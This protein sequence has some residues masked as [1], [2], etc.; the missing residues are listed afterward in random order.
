MV[1][2]GLHELVVEIHSLRAGKT[3]VAFEQRVLKAH[4]SQP[5]R[6]VAHIRALGGFR[7]VEIDVDD[8]VKGTNSD[9]NRFAQHFMIKRTIGLDVC[10]ENNRTKIA[11]RCLILTGVEGDLRAEV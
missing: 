8:I 1:G 7:R 4:Y 9:M 6:T 11:D 5:D 3:D 2:N 10:I